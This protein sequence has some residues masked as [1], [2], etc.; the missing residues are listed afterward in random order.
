MTVNMFFSLNK[1]KNN[2]MRVKREE[3]RFRIFMPVNLRENDTNI[4]DDKPLEDSNYWK[5]SQAAVTLKKDF[6]SFWLM[7]ELFLH[8]HCQSY[9]KFI[10]D[11]DECKSNPC[12]QPQSWCVNLY[13]SFQ[14]CTPESNVNECIGLEIT[15]DSS[16]MVSMSHQKPTKFAPFRSKIKPEELIKSSLG[17]WKLEQFGE[18]RN[19][20]AG[21]IIIGRGRIDSRKGGTAEKENISSKHETNHGKH[22]SHGKSAT[23]KSEYS[24]ASFYSLLCTKDSEFSRNIFYWM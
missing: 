3:K 11:I 17:E 13:G 14:C 5:Y 9:R 22:E 7:E 2:W 8:I 4:P 19:F 10:I 20:S 24:W 12:T 6:K 1:I 21:S 15:G 18:W 23:L 16:T